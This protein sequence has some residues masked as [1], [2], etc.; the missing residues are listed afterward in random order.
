MYTYIVQECPFNLPVAVWGSW[1]EDMFTSVALTANLMTSYVL[2][3]IIPATRIMPE[4]WS[5]CTIV[6]QIKKTLLLKLD[7]QSFLKHEKSPMMSTVPLYL[8]VN[9]FVHVILY[10]Y[11]L[12]WGYFRD[13]QFWFESFHLIQQWRYFLLKIIL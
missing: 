13:C 10:F 8:W 12:S 11:K 3:S 5:I 9:T 7:P 1:D 6:C 2:R 4:N